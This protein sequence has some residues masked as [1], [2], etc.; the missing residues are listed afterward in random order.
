MKP[1]ASLPF[2]LR[3][4]LFA[5]LVA[6]ASPAAADV[7]RL[8]NGD[9]LTGTVVSKHG[10]VLLLRTPYAGEVRIAW[11]EIVELLV[12]RP[13]QLMLSGGMPEPATLVPAAPGQAGVVRE[14][15]LPEPVD[16]A[17]VAYINPQPDQ[18]GTGIV[19][20]G[21]VNVAATYSR[22]NATN[23]RLYGEA[24]VEARAKAYRWNAGIK[25]NRVRDGPGS[26]VNSWLGDANLDRF[27]R[28]GHF[29]YARSSLEH[30]P[31]KDLELRAAGGA[32]YGWQIH[33]TPDLQ[34][35]LRGGLDYLHVDR[36]AGDDE[37]Y[38]ALGWALR[39]EQ[40]FANRKLQLFQE[41]EGFWNTRDLEH[42]VL[43]TKTG[44]RVPLFTSIEA[45]AQLNVDWDSEP[46][47]GR[48]PVD[49]V[50]LLGLGYKW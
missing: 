11:G 29:L 7:V 4:V 14:G 9:R 25:V 3:F 39:Y 33:D 42:V 50:W 6:A 34:L 47:A 23:D 45:T 38:P 28:K 44:V 48:E 46:A 18:S 40:W 1:K 32:G 43:R 37:S 49:S 24:Q 27:I 17:Q 13:V 20:R 8:R 22:G 5:T 26:A 35:S 16:L 41:Q 31:N 21:H 19:W 12:D 2:P 30:D 36:D 10:S 15:S